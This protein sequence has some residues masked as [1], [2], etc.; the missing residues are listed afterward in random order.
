MMTCSYICRPIQINV[1]TL[2]YIIVYHY[3]YLNV[4]YTKIVKLFTD[5]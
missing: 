2:K 4:I 5:P 3:F 1:R